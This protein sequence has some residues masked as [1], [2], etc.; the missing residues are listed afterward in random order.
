MYL[1]TKYS[2]WKYLLVYH[3][4][5]FN[6][7]CQTGTGNKWVIVVKRQISNFSTISWLEQVNFQWDDDDVRFVL[8]QHA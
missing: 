8:A 1:N 4:Y 3:H 6:F 5:N 7:P 2:A